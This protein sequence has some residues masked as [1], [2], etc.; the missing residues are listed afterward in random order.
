MLKG[1][2]IHFK[3][4]NISGCFC[5]PLFLSV[6][7]G[8][9]YFFQTCKIWDFFQWKI[10]KKTVSNFL[11]E[12]GWHGSRTI[13]KYQWECSGTKETILSIFCIHFNRH[14]DRTSL[15]LRFISQLPT[16][17]GFRKSRTAVW[18]SE[19]NTSSTVHWPEFP[20]QDLPLNN[21]M[22]LPGNMG[23][24]L[25]KLIYKR[26][27][28]LMAHEPYLVHGHNSLSKL[29]KVFLKFLY[30]I[31][32]CSCLATL[33]S[34][35]WFYTDR[36]QGLV[37]FAQVLGHI[38]ARPLLQKHSVTTG[39]LHIVEVHFTLLCLHER[40][41]LVPVLANRKKSGEDVLCDEKRPKA[42]A[43]VQPWVCSQPFQQHALRAARVALPRSVLGNL[44]QHR[45]I[46]PPQP[47][48]VPVVLG[49][50]LFPDYTPS[51]CDSIQLHG[52]I[53]DSY[54]DGSQMCSR[55]DTS[56]GLRL[57]LSN[58]LHDY[59]HLIMELWGNHTSISPEP[60]YFAWDNPGLCLW[61]H[62]ILSDLAC[63]LDF[64]FFYEVLSL[65]F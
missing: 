54:T 35:L 25:E 64:L 39:I 62:S 40:P 20:S 47:W 42:K 55:T 9:V 41:R 61:S 59:L 51:H 1:S 43:F 31:P 57:H 36:I 23:L 50:L 4:L 34:S 21:H 58:C 52:F 46:Q 65:L 2:L 18:C 11:V 27:H 17:F 63:A 45:S 38:W 10:P 6:A 7:L 5:Y 48:T 8:S 29:W 33:P 44:T 22:S 15:K 32:V 12:L 49:P 30:R 24:S 37:F 13:L 19:K 28:K 26:H 3:A 53:Y 16:R 60:S 56:H 14:A